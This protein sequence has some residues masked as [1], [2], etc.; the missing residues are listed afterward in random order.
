MLVNDIPPKIPF[1]P[2]CSWLI[3]GIYTTKW[4]SSFNGVLNRCMKY[5]ILYGDVSPIDWD[6]GPLL[7]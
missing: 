3:I 2:K 6:I 5:A 4:C 7:S 1:N